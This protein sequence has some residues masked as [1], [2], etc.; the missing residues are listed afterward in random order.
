[1]DNH[2]N[3]PLRLEN[4]LCFSVYAASHAFNR[5]Y[6][7]LLDALELTYPQYLVMV[8]L[9]E[10]DDQP[11][12]SIGEKLFLESSTLTPLLKRLE[13]AGLVKRTRDPKD[14]RSVRITL[15]AEGRELRQKALDVPRCVGEVA[16]LD[17]STIK[18]LIDDLGQ[19][20]DNLEANASR[21]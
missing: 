4:F 6:K 1:M 2:D 18:R 10:E 15:T 9:W 14:E 5:I 19:L 7:P 11:V 13:A 8:T 3:N 20:R 12:R 16:E 21:K 17:L